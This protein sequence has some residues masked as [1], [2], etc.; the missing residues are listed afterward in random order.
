MGEIGNDG[1]MH[2]TVISNLDTGPLWIYA[3]CL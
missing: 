2:Q 1:M 3:F